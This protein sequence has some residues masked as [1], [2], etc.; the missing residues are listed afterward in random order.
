MTQGV[1]LF[2]FNN[3]EI[4]YTQM[5]IYCAKQV[6]KFLNKPVSLVTDSSNWLNKQYSTDIDVFDQIISVTDPIKQQKNFYDGSQRYKKAIWKNFR[7]ADCYKLTPYDETLVIDTD[8]IIN[9]DFLNFCWEQNSDFIIY[10]SNNDLSGWRDTSEF[11]F[12]NEFSIPFYWATVFF[13]KKTQLNEKFFKL[14]EHIRDNWAYYS[15]VYQCISKKFR[16]DFAFS[17]AIHMMNGF[18]DGN[19]AT[20]IPNKM[21]YTLDRDFLLEHNDTTMKFLVQKKSN[22]KDYTLIKTNFLD[23][24]VMNKHSLLRFIRNA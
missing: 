22:I 18:T 4:D 16:N 2:A 17:I 7:R 14:V 8:Y 19:F 20:K 6:K 9:S 21:H 5:A 12:I 3:D 13:F 15:T 23:V 10:K 24:H 1:L 11:E